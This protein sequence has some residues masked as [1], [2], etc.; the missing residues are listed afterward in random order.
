MAYEVLGSWI[1]VGSVTPIGDYYAS[2]VVMQAGPMAEVQ[3]GQSILVD[4][5]GKARAVAPVAFPRSALIARDNGGIWLPEP[6]WATVTEGTGGVWVVQTSRVYDHGTVVLIAD[7]APVA[8][9]TG[10]YIVR[11]ADLIAKVV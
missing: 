8:F 3:Q 2:A 5:A 10:I 7:G 11:E 9:T 4:A 6:G 1:L